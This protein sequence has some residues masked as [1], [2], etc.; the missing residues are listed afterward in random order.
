M[1]WISLCLFFLFFTLTGNELLAQKKN[2]KETEQ[3]QEGEQQ[4][5]KGKKGKK[6]E[7]KKPAPPKPV[8]KPI[9]PK[10]IKRKKGDPI[11]EDVS[12]STYYYEMPLD[13]FPYI[14]AYMISK[15]RDD[16][17]A[18]LKDNQDFRK[19]FIKT[20]NAEK[21]FL[22]LSRSGDI[23]YTRLQKFI[24]KDSTLNVLIENSQ[25][26]ASCENDIKL[27][28]KK[29]REW[30]DVTDKKFPEFPSDAIYKSLKAQ[31]RIIYKGDDVFNSKGF[32]NKD[33]LRKAVV[34]VII[35]DERRIIIKEFD[36][37]IEL[38]EITYDKMK[39]KFRMRKL[40]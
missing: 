23:A 9:P 28:Q 25:C 22:E 7:V 40:D 38:Y 37:G 1:K 34:Y 33:V 30:T 24:S 35:P 20:R 4:P 29:D 2:K 31:Y 17:Y 6:S 8:K 13:Y 21:G 10:P 3:E 16:K 15:N 18:K 26:S 11:P 12:I 5:E 19:T 27:F 14:K 39:D 36:Q 32:E